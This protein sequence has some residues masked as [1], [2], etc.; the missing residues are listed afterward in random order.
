MNEQVHIKNKWLLQTTGFSHNI[1]KLGDLWEK[2]TFKI[3]D[4]DTLLKEQL[5]HLKSLISGKTSALKDEIEKYEA[6]TALH[7]PSK[8]SEVVDL[9]QTLTEYKEEE[10]Q[11]QTKLDSLKNDCLQF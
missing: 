7:M 8:R 2:F 9:V 10:D 6:K 3:S 1:E 4:F 5:E 11:L